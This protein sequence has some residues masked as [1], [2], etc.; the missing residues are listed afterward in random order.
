M[1]R[2]VLALALCAGLS[3]AQAARLPE[4]E[5]VPGGVAIVDLGPA[6]APRPEVHFGRRRV[7]V[8][9]DG[10]HWKAVLGLPLSTS[11]GHIELKVRQAGAMHTVGVDVHRKNYAV[12][13]ITLKNKEMVNPT[14]AQL[15][16]IHKD[17]IRIDKALARWSDTASVHTGF[18]LPVHAP[19]SSDFGLRRFFNGEPRKPHSG[20]DLAAGMGEPIR[21][22]ARGIVEDTGNFYFDG[23]MVMIDHG[24]GLVTVYCHM[25]K[26]DVKPGDVVEQG[27]VIGN[28]GATG[29]V[30]GPHLHWGVS[31]NDT[32]VDP[33]LFL[34][35]QPDGAGS[36]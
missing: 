35:E 3:V 9:E 23:N 18:I 16:R 21:A 12:Q 1:K 32:M 17:R 7:M 13:R 11:P 10:R 26:M 6:S 36:P 19:Q 29:R 15:K 30:T 20:L 34:T 2:I 8:A 33:H 5:P 22:P 28:V 25:S 14:A 27:Q 4:N 24:Q 31:L